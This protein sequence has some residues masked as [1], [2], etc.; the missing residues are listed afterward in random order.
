MYAHDSEMLFHPSSTFLPS[1][2][3][4]IAHM[5]MYFPNTFKL[6]QPM[7]EPLLLAHQ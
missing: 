6:A 1:T 7:L 5:T 4:A 3:F 2:T